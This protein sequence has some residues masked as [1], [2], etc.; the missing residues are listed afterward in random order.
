MRARDGDKNLDKGLIRSILYISFH[1][2]LPVEELLS[3]AVKTGYAFELSPSVYD[4]QKL[5]TVSLTSD[6][7]F[8]SSGAKVPVYISYERRLL[9]SQNHLRYHH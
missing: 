3:M 8:M 2:A 5:G 7:R 1:A 4:N 9:R 6:S